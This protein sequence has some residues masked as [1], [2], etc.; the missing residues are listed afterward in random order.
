MMARVSRNR[1][2]RGFTLV[3]MLVTLVLLSLIMLGL[4]GAMGTMGRTEESI[5][6]RLSWMDKA[7]SGEGFLR[8]VLSRISAK[9]VQALQQTGSSSYFFTGEAQSMS[10]VGVMPARY[11]VGGRYHFRL[12]MGQYQGEPAIVLSYTPWI[13]VQ[14]MPDWAAAESYPIFTHATSL[15]LQYQDGNTDPPAWQAAWSAPDALPQAVQVTIA[16]D[17]GV[18]PPLVAQLRVLPAG[19]PQGG[20]SSIGGVGS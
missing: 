13:D 1:S 14:T 3:E 2:Q 18:L 11:G 17:Q 12:A 8:S 6:N 10:W 5:D 15:S 7:R 9:K 4:A 19:D 16:S 20:G